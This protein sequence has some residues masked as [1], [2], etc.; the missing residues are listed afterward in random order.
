MVLRASEVTRI[1]EGNPRVAGLKDHLKHALP[2]FES[3][4]LLAIDLPSLGFGL[5]LS[6]FC[7]EGFSIEIMK[8][9][10]LVTLEERPR[11]S[12]F[13]PLHE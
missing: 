8:V 7:F 11:S 2:E 1:L 4:D 5:V 10:N 9:R 12:G 13:H 3:F 6:V